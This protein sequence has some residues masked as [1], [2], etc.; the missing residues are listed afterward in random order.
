MESEK[1]HMRH[2]LLCEC[3]KKSTATAACRNVCQIY[4]ETTIDEKA[5]AIDNFAN[6]EKE[7]EAPTI[8]LG[9]EGHH[10]QKIFDDLD[11]LKT[12]IQDVFDSKPPEFLP[13][14]AH[15]LPERWQEVID[16]YGDYAQS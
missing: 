9:V 13:R 3:D 16:S 8:R 14:G 1:E 11:Y 12:A 4:G 5:R 2:C 10:T 7:K 6:I 15:L